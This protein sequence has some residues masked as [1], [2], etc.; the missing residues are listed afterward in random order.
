MI[1]DIKNKFKNYKP[2]INGHKDMKKAS[3]L[4]PIIKKDDCY[5]ILFE[6]RSKNLRNQPN[7]ISFPGG[8]IEDCE[9]PYN[10]AI[11]E[12]CEELGTF[13]ENITI[14]SEIDLLITPSNLIIHPYV[15]Q[16]KNIS[17]LNINK[18]EV[19]HI[20]LVPITHLIKTKPL[21]Y[22]NIVKIIP[23][24]KFP[25]DIIPNNHNY[26]F[27]TGNYPVLF[28]NYENY[29]IWGIT[30]KILENFLDLITE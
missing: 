29:V 22:N 10:T 30:A 11:R 8:K 7:E 2:Y 23:N 1:D 20:F 21:L 19:D 3:V 26:K 13:E 4:I 5:H 12:T 28:Y 18:D 25:Y 9:T 24:E 17:N 16:I 6:V 27:D 15:G 14:I